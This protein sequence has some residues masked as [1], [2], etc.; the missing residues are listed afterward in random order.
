[1]NNSCKSALNR[2]QNMLKRVLKVL[3]AFVVLL[4]ISGVLLVN[5]V[6][7]Q[8][9]KDSIR[10]AV[11]A[12]TGYELTIAG[13]M[14]LNFFPS[15]GM[16]LNDVRLKNPSAPQELA[17]TSA[18][19]LQVDL[20]ALMRRE[21]LVQELSTDDLHLNF[22]I[23]A[24][25][26]NIWDVDFT[27]DENDT[28]GLAIARSVEIALEPLEDATATQ[29]AASI[30][31]VIAP[32]PSNNFSTVSFDRLQI[33][34]ASI[35]FQDLSQGVRYNVRNLSI[36]GSNTNL[37]GR[38]FDVDVAF[39]FL[40]NGMTKPL[41]MGLRAN[42]IADINNDSIRISDINFNITPLLL[43]GQIA[44][45]D[46][47]DSLSI[48]G[49]LASNGFDVIGLMETL[50]LS[51]VDADFNA[52]ALTEQTPLLQF[53]FEFGGSRTDFSIPR[54]S[55]SIGQTEIEADANIRF[56]TE[57]TPTNISY[58][59]ITNNIDITPFISEEEN[60]ATD[61]EDAP[62]TLPVAEPTAPPTEI[63]I[64]TELLSSVNVLG[65]IS[66]ESI[67]AGDFYF[68]DINAFTN[69][70][71]GVLDIEI[72]PV[73]IFDGTVQGNVRLDGSTDDAALSARLSVKQLNIIDI[74]PLVSRFNAVTGKLDLEVDYTA[75][76]STTAQLRDSVSG[77][78]TFAI[79]ENSVDITLIKQV[80]TTIDAL[81]PNGGDIQQWPDVI[82]FS[83]IG[84][85]IVMEDGVT[86]NQQ[87]KLRMDNLDLS[88]AGGVDLVAESF[89]YDLLFTVVGEPALQ[90]IQVDPLYHNVSWPVQCEASFDDD[91]SQYCRPD[92]T[93][94]R[95]IF[96]Q[97]GSNAIRDRL[98]ES[99]IDQ[100]PEELQD[101]ARGL[102]R[103]LLN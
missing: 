53:D 34:N 101:S 92:F 40:N 56:A 1:M 77:S 43:Q 58:D 2:K 44:L 73:S 28:A 7:T 96:T 19:I 22:F 61:E 84:G 98:N 68:Q 97:I 89:N 74:A 37:D 76:G 50:G 9:N 32:N 15:I 85:Y 10:E 36:D 94:V 75:T 65:S 80:F 72:Q 6:N 87:V 48:S 59:I 88:G 46:L 3:L 55:A 90:T 20:R 67:T 41:P 103:G 11:L 86:E 17:S 14:D 82:Q 79:T 47:N 16:T 60:I 69:S 24:S 78:T 23:D 35:D 21:L 29:S 45:T 42:V 5:S 71:N 99:I 52:D 70:E 62:G 54:F 12:S 8:R 51:E 4:V 27:A 64:P 95:E 83:E 100:V 49:G 57:F 91:V 81:N 102:L 13:D 63:I 38:P 18:A 93:Q 31:D 33:S 39:D 26:K 66:I 25:G 30:D